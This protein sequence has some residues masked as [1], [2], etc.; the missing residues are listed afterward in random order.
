MN[1]NV[2]EDEFENHNKNTKNNKENNENNK[3]KCQKCQK[4]KCYGHQ[5]VKR[6][7]AIYLIGLVLWFVL[8]LLLDVIEPDIIVWIFLF[9][10]P[11]IYLINLI[12]IQCCSVKVEKEMFKGNF[13]SFGF[14]I[15]IIL[16]NWNSPLEGQDKSKF[17][18]LLVVA[19]ILIMV[20]LVDIWV[21]IEHQSIIKHLKTVLH[22]A[23]LSLL[24]LALYLYYKFYQ[25]SCRIHNLNCNNNNNNNKL[26]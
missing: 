16:L 24:A 25:D 22:T 2:D 13:L 23:A 15:T 11:A 20:S 5:T 1:W 9:L 17:F 6:V 8:I 10:P 12:N 7:E 3:E 4:L 19:F 21:G 14:L 18:K 26:F